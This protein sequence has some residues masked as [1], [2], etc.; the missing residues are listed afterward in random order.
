M[1]RTLRL[2]R[3]ASSAF[4]RGFGE[5]RS[6][7]YSCTRAPERSQNEA[8]TRNRPACLALKI[9]GMGGTRGH[10]ARP[11]LLARA[12]RS[13]VTENPD[14]RRRNERAAG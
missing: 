6:G 3:R 12:E 4:W 10:G 1:A 11:S 13:S 7:A 14:L 2:T 9:P 8:K 5:H